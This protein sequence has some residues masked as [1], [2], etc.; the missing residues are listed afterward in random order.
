M[1]T[2]SDF[3]SL[4]DFFFT[5][6]VPLTKELLCP[7]DLPPQKV[8]HILTTLIWSL[9]EQRDWTR[10]GIEMASKKLAEEW[11]LHHKKDIMPILFGAVMGRKHGLP[12]FDSFEILGLH[13]AR[14]RLMQAIH[15]LGGISTKENSLLKVLRQERRLGEWD[16]AFQSCSTHP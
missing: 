13:Q 1:K 2:L 15:F 11:G 8:A 16:H 10:S 3:F 9:E 7:R 4:S 5:E 14:V 12:L 6:E